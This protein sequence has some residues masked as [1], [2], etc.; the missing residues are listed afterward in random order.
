MSE[1]KTILVTGATGLIGRPLCQLLE[2]R[3]HCV[4]T[5]SRGQRGDFQWDP[6]KGELPEAAVRGID[7]VIHLAGESVAQRWT[8]EAKQRI[9]SS[10]VQSTELLARRILESESRPVF[11][12][13][14]GINYYGY[15]RNEP[16]D[17]N[18]RQG[19]GF[20]AQV[21]EQWEGAVKPL[22]EAGSRCV[23]VRTGVVLSSAGGALAK[24]LPPFKAGA[25]GRIGDGKQAMSWISLHDLVRL[26]V[27]CLEDAKICGPINAVAPEPVSNRKFA[28]TLGKVL[29]RPTFIPTPAFAIRTLF[30]EMGKETVLSNLA[31]QPKKL[32]EIKFDWSYPDLEAA[33]S[34]T[35]KE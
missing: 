3:G 11:I 6:G 35:L 14:S 17:E 32:N 25:G 2:D 10:R 23:Y 12:T 28:E 5:L 19:N 29:G 8:S 24:M 21:C 16:V 9:L 13:A 34:H 1:Q 31:V 27:T 15:N 20:L 18:S 26:Y 4:R 7:A 33:L 22:E 30:G